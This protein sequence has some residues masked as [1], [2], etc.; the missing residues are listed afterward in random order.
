MGEGDQMQLYHMINVY[1]QGRTHWQ[2]GDNDNLFDFTYA[3]NVAHALLLAA[4][5]LLLTH[6][7]TMVPLDHERVDGEAFIISN[8]EPVYFWDYMRMV[9]REAGSRRGTEHVWVMPRGVGMMLGLLS[10]VFCGVIRKP[11]TFTRQRIVYSCMTRYYNID[12][13]KHR[14]GYKPLVS[15]EDAVKRSVAWFLETEKATAHQL[16]AVKQ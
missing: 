13:A 4:R 11:P 14:L 16:G 10:E 9:W 3:E 2:I 8:D 5:A 15:L 12:K 6:A 7:S 1:R